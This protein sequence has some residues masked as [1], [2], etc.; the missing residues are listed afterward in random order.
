MVPEHLNSLGVLKLAPEI[1]PIELS[2][3]TQNVSLS[4][5]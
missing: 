3:R 1:L 5:M 4:S 2:K